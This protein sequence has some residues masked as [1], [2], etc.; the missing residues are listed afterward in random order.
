MYLANPT[1]S[2]AV[3][4]AMRAGHL[5]LIDTP[6][7]QNA[8][9]TQLAHE[10]GVPWCADNGCFSDRWDEARWWRFLMDNAH[11]AATCLFAVA[12]DVVGDHAAT[13]DRSRPWLPKLRALGYPAAFVLQDGASRDSVPWGDFDVLFIG[14]ST[15]FKLGAQAR[16]LAHEAHRRGLWVHCG[17]VNS[18]RRWA[19][20]AA[21]YPYGLG[22]D[23]ADGT[24]LTYGPDRNLP[25]LLAWT[26]SNAQPALFGGGV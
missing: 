22:A 15:A 10:A 1:G 25:Q 21:P 8:T 19:Y 7:Q 4:E 11:R 3:L 17:R 9:Q 26:R 6:A 12:P 18:A 20:A 13:L 16:Q 24:F 5:G 23:S 14:G 2:P